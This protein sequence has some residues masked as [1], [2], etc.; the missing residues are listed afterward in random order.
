M[1]IDV[2][3]VGAYFIRD[4]G[5]DDIRIVSRPL[6]TLPVYHYLQA[7]HRNLLPELTLVMQELKDQGLLDSPHQVFLERL[8]ID[9]LTLPADQLMVPEDLMVERLNRNRLLAQP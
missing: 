6:R 2:D 9:S 5:L 3:A 4:K 7:K 1:A 8:G